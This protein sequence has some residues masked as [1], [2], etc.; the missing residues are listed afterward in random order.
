MSCPALGAPA[1]TAG[2][3]L[4]LDGAGLT[5][6]VLPVCTT[7]LQAR[8]SCGG[9]GAGLRVGL[10]E[11]DDASRW[12]WLPMP[13]ESGGETY[14]RL[15][16]AARGT[17]STDDCAVI[18]AAPPEAGMRRPAVGSTGPAMLEAVWGGKASEAPA[19]GHAFEDA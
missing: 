14:T 13:G 9:M 10:R 19:W 15:S 3:L 7:P 4:G 16:R 2:G 8:C 6:R 11:G 12:A 5:A 1:R 18:L 17:S